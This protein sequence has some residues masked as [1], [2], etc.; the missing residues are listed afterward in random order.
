MWEFRLRRGVQFHDGT[1]FTADDAIFSINRARQPSS[2]L[3]ELLA[4]VYSV[5]RIDAVTITIKTRSRTPLLPAKLTHVLMMS[6]AWTERNKVAEVPDAKAR[7]TA[8]TTRNANGTGAFSLVSREPGVRTIMRRNES[9]WRKPDGLTDITELI[10]RPIRNDTERVQALVSG[11]VDFMQDVP[12]NELP[13]L[14]AM[15]AITVNVG[16]SNRSVFLGLNVGDIELASSDIKARNPFADKTRAARRQ[17]GDQPPDAAAQ[18][19]A[20]P[21]AADRHAGVAERQRLHPPTRP[22]PPDRSGQ[23]QGPHCRSR[24]SQWPRRPSR[25]PQ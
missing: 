9:Y 2:Q 11:D 17:H 13:R 21:R 20:R 12:V 1:P 5:T 22:D 3:A 23:S 25:L 19:A 16:P 10:Y 7:A 6:K 18:R 8:F 14:R 15:Q 24:L 4:E